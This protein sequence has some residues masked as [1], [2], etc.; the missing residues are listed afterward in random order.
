MKRE[1]PTM[2]RRTLKA[3]LDL[4][5]APIEETLENRL[6][7]IV[8]DAQ[9]HCSR[10]YLSSMQSS[11]PSAGT[12][13]VSVKEMEPAEYL[14]TISL[15]ASIHL[16]PP[17]FQMDALAQCSIPNDSSSSDMPQ[18][19]FPNDS[20]NTGAIFQDSAYY[21]QHRDDENIPFDEASLR[22]NSA[23]ESAFEHFISEF[24]ARNPD[25]ETVAPDSTLHDQPAEEY[26]GKGKGRA[27]LDSG[28]ETI[29]LGFG[30]F[31]PDR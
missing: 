3:L 4:N 21:S 20:S 13:A 19:S 17:Y 12:I 9:E 23:G 28:P 2:V 30:P 25:F 16:Q 1:L 29:H 11:Q 10:S 18:L 31:I 24:L 5:F 6:E 7:S 27:D 14:S 8:R 15:N 26:T 22:S